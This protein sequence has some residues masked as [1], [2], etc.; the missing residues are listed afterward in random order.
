[1][2]PRLAAVLSTDDFAAAELTAMVLD[3]EAYRLD[4]CV[5]PIDEIPEPVI[6]AR[7]LAT[8]LLPRL[9]VEQHTAAWIWGALPSAP[10]IVE[11]CADSSAR[12][13]PPLGTRLSVREVVIQHE[14]VAHLGGIAVTTPLRT[15]I[16]L[17]RFVVDWRID[18]ETAVAGLMRLGGFNAIDCARIMNR[19]RNLP[20]KRL[21]LVRLAACQVAADGGV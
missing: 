20:G 18:D 8:E 12:A 4:A 17:A 13:R 16:D 3:G 6:R 21:A 10:A 19:R 9:I 1:M 14:D 11:V 5:A 2:T 15:A 7:S